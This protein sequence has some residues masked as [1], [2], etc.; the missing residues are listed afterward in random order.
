MGTTVLFL[1]WHAVL[2]GPCTSRDFTVCSWCQWPGRQIPFPS[3][4]L[5]LPPPWCKLSL[6]T[7]RHLVNQA[8]SRAC[9]ASLTQHRTGCCKRPREQ[10]FLPLS[11]I[12]LC[13][14]AIIIFFPRWFL[15]PVLF[16]R[17]FLAFQSASLRHP[18]VILRWEIGLHKVSWEGSCLVFGIKLFSLT[19]RPQ[20]SLQNLVLV[21]LVALGEGQCLH[22]LKN[23]GNMLSATYERTYLCNSHLFKSSQQWR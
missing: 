13:S 14:S 6:A 23:E 11:L 16:S 19:R 17:G 4:L 18:S 21:P 20:R 22:D 3:A 12:P 8:E 5:C 15:S 1:G 7:F 10:A 2:G 9:L